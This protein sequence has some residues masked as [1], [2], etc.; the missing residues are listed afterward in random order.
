MKKDTIFIT[1]TGL[2]LA[3]AL[4]FQLG[5]RLFAQ[6]VVGPMVNFVLIFSAIYV[7]TLS[8]VIIGAL[9]PLIAFMVGIMPLFPVVPFV[10]IGN[11]LL[12]IVFNYIR[13]KIRLNTN[14][15]AV[16]VGALVKYG[17]LAI[18]ARYMV[19]L[20]IP[21]VPPPLVASLS[22]PQLY[23]AL[24]GGGLA[25]VVAEVVGKALVKEPVQN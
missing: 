23:T 14:Y 7:G 18:S 20:F 25:V 24:V 21:V 13:Q 19:G 10:M 12:V 8:G 15:V 9:T 11:A 1:R 3:L 5:F 17:F 22:L 4:V 2:L 6:P 16:V